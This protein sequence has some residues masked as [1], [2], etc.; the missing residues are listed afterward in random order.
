M[1]DLLSAE[2]FA[3]VPVAL[4]VRAGLLIDLVPGT[5]DGRI[6]CDTFAC[7]MNWRA[8][9]MGDLDWPSSG[10][11]PGGDGDAAWF[12]CEYGRQIFG[13]ELGRERS[14]AYEFGEH[15]RELTTLHPQ[16]DQAVLDDPRRMP[17]SAT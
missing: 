6:V 17:K 12:N 4:R 3:S 14:R 15:D 11:R 7:L 10:G 8:A 5:S 16:G 9:M 1:G 2:T 13:I